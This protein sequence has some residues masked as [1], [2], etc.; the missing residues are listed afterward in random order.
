MQVLYLAGPLFAEAER[1][2]HRETKRLLL[3]TATRH[4][5]AIEVLWPY[6]LI[7]ADEITALGPAARPEIFRR[8]RQGLERAQVLIA[9]LDGVQVDDGTAW[10]VGYFYATKAP[11][12]RIIGIRTDFRRA[13]E[14]PEAIVNAMIEMACDAIVTTRAD[15]LVQLFG[16]R[17][18]TRSHSLQ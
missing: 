11:T 17:H 14:S 1:D 15:L 3:E 13:G 2:W 7:S 16:E 12:A 5:R 10:E 18:S 6:E 9:L 8:C 4:G